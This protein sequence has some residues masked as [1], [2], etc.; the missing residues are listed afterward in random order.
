MGRDGLRA[1]AQQVTSPQIDATTSVDAREVRPGQ[2]FT[3]ITE[4]V[5]KQG[6]HVY[7]PGPHAY[8]VIA[9]HLAPQ[10]FVR[11]RP[12][13]YPKAEIYY[14]APLKERVQTYQAPFSLRT[15]VALEQSAAAR[16]HFA[17]MSTL[18]LHGT[19]DYQAC[20]DRLCFTPVSLPVVFTVALEPPPL[21]RRP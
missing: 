2:R 10:P 18:T 20:N 21:P 5:P 7:A 15:P 3:L 6:L 16:Q 11:V 12:T 19:L 9:L 17:T 8:T 14:F 1:Q 4:V 13:R